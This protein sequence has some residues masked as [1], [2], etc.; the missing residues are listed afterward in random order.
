MTQVRPFTLIIPAHNEETVIARCLATAI[1]GMARRDKM[2]I[3]VAANGCTDDTVAIARESAPEAQILDLSEG[4]KT[5]AINA[6]LRIAKHAPAIILDAD[7]ECRFVSLAALAEALDKPGVM[8][9]APAIRLNLDRCNWFVRA[10][11]RAWAEQPYAKAGKGGAGCYGLSREAIDQIGEF[12]SIIG[13]DIW[14]H[15]RFADDAK[16]MVSETSDGTPVYSIVRP[17]RTATQQIKVEA[18]RQLGNRE[19]R[20]KYPSPHMTNLAG[21]QGLSVALRSGAS[22]I[23]LIVFYA[24]KVLAR[25]EARLNAWRGRGAMWTRDLTSRQA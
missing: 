11:Y 23:N 21:Q 14:I 5:G 1:D 17:P 20:Q 18:R 7:V 10:Y 15:T 13:D 24:M 3:I 6:A 16:R 9:A 25:L 22:P 19:V 2:E 8:T 12:P 4:S